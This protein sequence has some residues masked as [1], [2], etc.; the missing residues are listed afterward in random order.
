[1][2]VSCSP[3][4]KAA[5]IYQNEMQ[6]KEILEVGYS[7]W[8]RGEVSKCLDKT[9]AHGQSSIYEGKPV[10]D[11]VSGMK[12]VY[13]TCIASKDKAADEVAKIIDEINTY[14]KNASQVLMD[15]AKGVKPRS[16]L[17]GL[18]VA[19]LPKVL[20]LKLVVEAAEKGDL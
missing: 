19:L 16:A 10:V 7:K 5:A 17:L 11:R 9:S 18:P 14:D 20:R 4:T 1:M 12:Q 6:T 2:L 3:F 15:V 13:N 8:Y